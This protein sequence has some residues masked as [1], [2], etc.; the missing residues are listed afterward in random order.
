MQI[1]RK[2]IQ[3]KTDKDTDR[4]NCKVRTDKNANIQTDK[5]MKER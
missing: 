3:G 2:L 5:V 1:K 4:Q